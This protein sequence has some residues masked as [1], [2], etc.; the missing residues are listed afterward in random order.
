MLHKLFS[1]SLSAWQFATGKSAGIIHSIRMFIT[2][3]CVLLGTCISP[4]IVAVSCGIISLFLVLS[5]HLIGVTC[6][7]SRGYKIQD[8][9]ED[10]AL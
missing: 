10:S 1:I 5:L 8:V 2:A 4:W 9:V 3:L 6:K 7:K